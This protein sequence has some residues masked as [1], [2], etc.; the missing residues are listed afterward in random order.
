MSARE[1]N[2]AERLEGR[3][4]SSWRINGVTQASDAV[5]KSGRLDDGFLRRCIETFGESLDIALRYDLGE[6]RTPS[7][8]LN[9][10]GGFDETSHR[11][12][13][14]AL[15]SSGFTSE[16]VQ[17]TG[18]VP[19]SDATVEYAA[20][21][22][23]YVA[24]PSAAPVGFGGALPAR[25]LTAIAL[26]SS[27]L[28]AQDWCD[29]L[30]EETR[31]LSELA[32]VE[33]VATGLTVRVDDTLI[34]RRIRLEV[35]RGRGRV[36]IGREWV[37]PSE[38]SAL[39]IAATIRAWES[40]PLGLR[41]AVR[42][43]SS[44]A[45]LRH[46]LAR[47]QQ[48]GN[49]TVGATD[50]VPPATRLAVDLRGCAPACEWLPPVLPRTTAGMRRLGPTLPEPIE[51]E[52]PS[53]G[54]LLGRAGANSPGSQVRLS[55][56]DRARHMMVLGGSGTGKTTM[57]ASAVLSDIEQG[58]GA[59]VIDPHG[60][61]SARVVAGLSAS[62]L[63]DVIWLRP[64]ADGR[65]FT[66]NLLDVNPQAQ[67]NLP[68]VIAAEVIRMFDRLYDMRVC[69]GPMFEQYMRAA[70][71]LVMENGRGVGT[72]LDVVRLF[73]D[74][75]FRQELLETCLNPTVAAFWSEVA[76]K[77]SGETA[78]PAMAAYVTSK[79]NRFVSAGVMRATLGNSHSSVDLNDLL[80][81]RKVVLF[82]LSV[83]TLGVPDVQLLGMTLL[84]RMYSLAMDRAGRGAPVPVNLYIDEAQLFATESLAENLAQAR[85]GGIAF[86]LANQNL[87]QLRS[88][89]DGDRLMQSFLGNAANVV[90]FRVNPYDAAVL[91]PL[92][93]RRFQEGD[94][95]RLP[96]FHAAARVLLDGRP[97]E[98]F[99]LRVDPPRVTES[100]GAHEHVVQNSAKYTIEVAGQA[101]DAMREE[102]AQ[103]KEKW[104]R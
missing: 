25:E 23:V 8:Q 20:L 51:A 5:Q 97:Q 81:G 87:S 82:D 64:G 12:A 86:V 72:L 80:D 10:R 58:R 62:R 92:F 70:L 83:G 75:T 6:S 57:L 60:D 47:C 69:G 22:H 68:S 31:H 91:G 103:F 17:T 41:I 100:P 95:E 53:S 90:A 19:A 66:L 88:A 50:E 77:V 71:L 7:L 14:M 13:R 4:V 32:A 63:D 33:V 89:P 36:W 29:R 43:D 42:V 2:G 1:R 35:E 21:P 34:M 44:A 49:L 67:P 11:R 3:G 28:V 78:L 104:N 61:L 48:P 16:P 96:D 76:P 38:E 59:C 37:R 15:A 73:H 54:V 30:L 102:W 45:S 94:L 79:L 55:P 52:W 98:P 56:R 26:S 65:T 46:T 93:Q 9:V 99:A 18:P 24:A 85:K 39:W 27:A 101:V 84:A 40:A 74:K